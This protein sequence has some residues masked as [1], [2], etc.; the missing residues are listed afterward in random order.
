MLWLAACALRPPAA[1]VTDVR[2]KTFVFTCSDGYEFVARLV[3]EQAWI[4]TAEATVE[5]RHVSAASGA[6]Y[7]GEDVVFWSKGALASL[8]WGDGRHSDCRN[9]PQRA[10]WEHAK[11]DGVDFRAVGNEPGWYLEIREQSRILLVSD[12]GTSRYE[13]SLSSPVVDH[14]AGTTRYDAHAEG[15]DL[16]VVLRAAACRDSMSGEG[17]ET[18]VLLTLDG[19]SLRGCGR[20]LH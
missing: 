16:V 3:G 7:T 2:P 8:D 1:A 20:P 18:E 15:H 5:L 19:R 11:L 12:Y 14:D 17:F 10:V 13:F 6:K 9:D 4:F